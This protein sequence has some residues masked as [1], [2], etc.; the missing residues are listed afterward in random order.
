MN[1]IFTPLLR[2]GVLVYLDDI[3][4]YAKT[5]EEH[6]SLLRQVLQIL[7]GSQYYVKLSKCEFEKQELKYL[8]HI[9][10]A[11]GIKVDPAKTKAVDQWPQPNNQRD[12]RA[13]LGLA[14]YFRKFV[15]NFSTIAAPLTCLTR[16]DTTFEWT[17]AC[18]QAFEGIKHGLTHAPVLAS[19]D[20]SKPFEVRCDASIVGVG[21]VLIQDDKPIAYES[22]KLD[23]TQVKWTTTEQELWAVVHALQVWRCY[24]E[25]VRFT[26]VTDHN[27]FVASKRCSEL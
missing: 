22:K 16:K 23:D 27:P 21:A 18:Q 3:L 17:P 13:F 12:V 24:L 25:G 2:K 19:P 7:Q 14:N 26:V 6:D 15:P 9:V 4:V 8:G 5:K 10:G 20:P 1:R 11:E